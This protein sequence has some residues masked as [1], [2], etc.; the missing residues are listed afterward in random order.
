MYNVGIAGSKRISEYLKWKVNVSN[1][2]LLMFHISHIR[3]VLVDES[4]FGVKKGKVKF[5][6]VIRSI[7]IECNWI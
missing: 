1:Q 4:Y 2:L 5:I 6:W 7:P 3:I